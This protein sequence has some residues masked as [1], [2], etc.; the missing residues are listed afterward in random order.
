MAYVR[1]SAPDLGRMEQ[2]LLD[3][4]MITAHR[5]ARRLY[6]RGAGDAPYLHVTELGPPGVVSFA[7]D[8]DDEDALRS[9]AR[10]GD[11]SPV[12]ALDG[13]G[14]GKR[15]RLRDPN[16]CWI[17]L[18]TGRATV[19]PMPRRPNVR[20]PDGVSKLVGAARVV[21]LSHTA[22]MTP[23]PRP[24]IEWYQKTLGV[25]P[26]DELYIGSRDNLLGQFNRVDRGEELVDHHIVFVI[27]GR[28][29]GMHHASYAVEA[30]D[31]LFFGFNHL[32][33]GGHDHVRG[34]GRHAL[35]SQI[36]DYW[37]SPFNQMHEHWFA[38]ERMNASSG[39]NYV[40]IGEGMV[41]DTGDKPPERFTKQATPYV[42]W[43]VP[44]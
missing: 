11:A 37:M 39:M 8:V 1:L 7:Y 2:F 34:I 26:T 27:K 10:R 31:D 38:G 35:G 22:C 28:E 33:R 13:P 29:R 6:M 15:V 20:P 44:A 14:G 25:I 21:R 24:T 32:D 42:D 30:P 12:E 5:D 36:F 23:E 40:Q 41:H 19:E 3:F 9:M 18:V 43:P 16:G 17:E 4:G